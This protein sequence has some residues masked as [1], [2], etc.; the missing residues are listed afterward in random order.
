MEKKKQPKVEWNRNALYWKLPKGKKVVA[1]SI[2]SGCPEKVMIKRE[3]HPDW[4]T[5][6][7]W[8]GGTMPPFP[9]FVPPF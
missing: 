6:G 8:I 2:Y 3:G 1:D 4:V 9:P 5:G 7:L